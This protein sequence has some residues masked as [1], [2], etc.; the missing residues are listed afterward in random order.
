MSQPDGS[1]ASVTPILPHI[2]SLVPSFP[3]TTSRYFVAK[4]SVMQKNLTKGLAAGPLEA[5]SRTWPGIGELVIL[6]LVGLFF[7]T[8][9][10]S[11]PVAAPAMLL[12]CQ[13]LGQCRIRSFRD[14]VSGAFLVS[15]IQ[16]YEQQSKRLVPEALTF[17]TQAIAVLAGS[18]MP[19]EPGLYHTPDVERSELVHL[20]IQSNDS[21]QLEQAIDLLSTLRKVQADDSSKTSLL[22]TLLQCLDHFITMYSS[23][24]AAIEL[25]KPIHSM[26]TSI[27]SS[28]SLPSIAQAKL[29]ASTQSISRILSIASKSRRPLMLQA[30]KPIPI[31]TYLPKFE[32]GYAPGRHFDPD[33]ERNETQ[34]LQALV[35]KEKKGAIRELR[36]DNRF[37][38]NEKSKMAREKDYQYRNRMNR[39]HASLELERADEK[40][41]ERTKET[42]RKRD[43]RRASGSRGARGG[44]GGKR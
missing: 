21:A 30:H 1:F 34:K 14:I 44:R 19:S 12:M 26:L 35:R 32:D 28:S 16:Q 3:L 8:S 9:D 36:K 5:S 6:R 42:E 25:L 31:R 41:F 37:L 11:H 24:P 15:L 43:Q 27:D 38:A 13:Y 23:L 20:R 18:D 2:T 7:S 4:L 33:S 39:A 17:L 29:S 40:R 22:L 10:F